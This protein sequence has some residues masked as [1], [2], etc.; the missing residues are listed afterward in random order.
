MQEASIARNSMLTMHG[1]SVQ[2][3]RQLSTRNLILFAIRF[4][5]VVCLHLSAA[6]KPSRIDAR[7]MCQPDVSGV[8]IAFA[9]LR[10][11]ISGPLLGGARRW[12]NEI[13][14]NVLS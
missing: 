11:G 6:D 10:P 3:A 5:A 7:M 8:R 4:T 12:C 9:S 1:R 13:D 2:I 14:L